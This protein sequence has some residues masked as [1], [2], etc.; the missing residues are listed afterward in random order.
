MEESDNTYVAVTDMIS[1]SV[2]PF[3]LEDESEPEEGRY[4]WGYQ[5]QIENHG[6]DSVQLE[7][8]HWKITDSMGRTQEVHGEGV[9]GEQPVIEPGDAFEYTSG[10]PLA[11]PSGFMVGTFE[12]RKSDGSYFDVNIPAFSLDSPFD[13]QM[14]N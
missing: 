11:T 8:R 1:V 5:I 3:F 12:M 13:I 10:A 2:I 7:R 9:V 4:M 14:I 6:D